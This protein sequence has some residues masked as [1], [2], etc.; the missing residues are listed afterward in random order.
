MQYLH[1]SCCF[2]NVSSLFYL[3]HPDRSHVERC[4]CACNQLHLLAHDPVLCVWSQYNRWPIIGIEVSCV[5]WSSC[6]TSACEEEIN[7]NNAAMSR[8]PNCT[9]PSL[10]TSKWC[11][12]E[13]RWHILKVWRFNRPLWCRHNLWQQLSERTG[14]FDVICQQRANLIQQ[15]C[16]LGTRHQLWCYFCF[17][18]LY[19]ISCICKESHINARGWFEQSRKTTYFLTYPRWCLAMQKDWFHFWFQITEGFFCCFY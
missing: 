14:L 11:H 19:Y 15:L 5:W 18:F 6:H 3:S 13:I 8:W 4:S 7:G 17:N 10:A 16:P 2:L 12:G 9:V 1:L